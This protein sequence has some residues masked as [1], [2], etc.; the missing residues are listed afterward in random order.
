M[1]KHDILKL[2]HQFRDFKT[3]RYS[4]GKEALRI[5]ESQYDE[6][7]LILLEIMMPGRSGYYH[8]EEIKNHG[9]FKKIPVVLF[10][11]KSFNEDI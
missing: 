4:N 10:T 7:F 2:P 3:I 8:L 5:I 1:E 6:I 11:T 9:L